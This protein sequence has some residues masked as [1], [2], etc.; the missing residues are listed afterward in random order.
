MPSRFEFERA[1]RRSE[2][3]PLSRLLALTIATWADAE[4][5]LISRRNQP[6]QSV[7]LEATGMSKSAFLAH[8]KNLVDGGW[9]RCDSP[10]PIK[11]QKEHAQNVYFVLIPDGKAGSPGDLAKADKRPGKR[12]EP[13]S[14]DDLA[15]GRQA[16]QPNGTETAKS[17]SNLGRQATT[18]V[19]PSP[20][21]HLPADEGG[22]ASSDERT[23]R[24]FDYCQPL[25]KAMTEAGIVVSWT[26]N[27]DDW[28]AVAR[29]LDRAGVD[30]MVTFARTAKSREPIRFAK[31]FL[32]AGWSGLPPKSTKPSSAPAA[33]GKRPHCGHP[34][35]DPITRT[36]EI[37]ND[38][39]LRNLHP[40]PDCHPTAKGQA[41]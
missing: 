1:I 18:R 41:A 28:Q 5:G 29:V 25:I 12:R 24:A 30:A 31:F 20:I 11:A 9:V 39:G 2:L 35:C 8:R 19:L 13:R 33:A 21:S 16:T 3:P 22:Q 26:M 7:L 23:P 10:D 38:R 15:L 17:G 40:C 37:E 27:A 36:R 14:G 6:A 4:T 34:D 32:R